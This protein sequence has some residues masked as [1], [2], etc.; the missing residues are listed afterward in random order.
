MPIDCC[1]FVNIMSYDP[2]TNGRYT[3]YNAR[4]INLS[5]MFRPLQYNTIIPQRWLLQNKGC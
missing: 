3:V 4:D 2:F 5:P 1:E